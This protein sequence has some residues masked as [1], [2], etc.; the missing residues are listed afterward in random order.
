MKINYQIN[1]AARKD[2]DQ[3]YP[4]NALFYTSNIKIDAVPN[5]HMHAFFIIE[6]QIQK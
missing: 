4:N 2:P 5:F 3:K 1:D 6:S